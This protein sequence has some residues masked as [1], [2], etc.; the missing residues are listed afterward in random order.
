MINSSNKRYKVRYTLVL[1]GVLA[2]SGIGV[3]GKSIL[4]KEGHFT[5]PV[6]IGGNFGIE[7]SQ[8]NNV[9]K[10]PTQT[11][12][13]DIAD[14]LLQDKLTVYYELD[15]MEYSLDTLDWN[16]QYTVSPATF[17]L[18]LQCLNPIVYLT[19]AYEITENKQYLECAEEFL[20]KWNEYR[21]DEKLSGKNN[22]VWYDHGTALR[23][24]NIIYYTLVA[25]EAQCLTQETK[26]LIIE[27]LNLHAE[28]LAQEVNYTKNHN[29][30]IFQDRALI[31]IAYFLNNENKQMWLEIAQERL[32]GQIEHAFTE[33]M[34]HVENS[35]G[36]Q[37]GVIELFR[38]ISEFLN[39][40]EDNFGTQLYDS[41]KESM[42]FMTYITKP[43]GVVASIGDTNDIVGSTANSNSYAEFNNAEFTYASTCGEEGTQPEENSVFYPKSG[44]YI[45]HNDWDVENYKQSTWTMFKSGFK[46]KTHKHADDN[47]FML[48]SKGYDIFVDPGWYNYTYG[49]KY[50]D[51]FISSLAHNSVIVDGKSY[52]VTDENSYK[53]G[54]Y[55]YESNDNYD[56]I[57][58]YNDMYNDV[59]IDRHFYN[60][61]DAIILYDD[62][63]SD[64]EHTYSQLFHASEYMEV[65]SASNNEVLFS[66]ADTEY[67]VRIKQLLENTTV[68]VINGG[69]EDGLFGHISRTMNHIDTID[70]VKF[71]ITG[72]NVELVTLITIED[73]QGNIQDIDD[74]QFNSTDMI[75]SIK[76]NSDYTIKLKSRE[77]MSVEDI[78]IIQDENEFTFINNSL[79]EDF[80]Y[81]W[82]VIDK[83]NGK[84]IHKQ[85]Y[86]K[87]NHFAYAFNNPGEYLVR[88]Y[89]KNSKGQ[90]KKAIVGVISFNEESNSW[91]NNGNQYP[92]LNLKY[93]GHSYTQLDSDTYEFN[94][95]YNYSLNS[96]IKWYIYKNSVYYDV[97]STE[98]NGKL[99]YIFDEPGTYTIMYYL[100]TQEKDNEFYNFPMITIN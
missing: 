8:Y 2:I 10:F 13:I 74:I 1:I 90:M 68:N 55:D 53:T 40:F 30:G 86:S 26:G 17:Q 56:Y 57:V 52:S 41:I 47:S 69:S 11:E 16:V 88:G 15:S 19:R 28:F 80:Y 83:E 59:M 62:I 64:T 49:D 42:K 36:Y 70:T 58:G 75:F 4:S 39:Q 24:E 73:K 78:E 98:N 43:N 33:E 77:R 51:Y 82:Y 18:Y 95:N 22:M 65:I 34:V 9:Y 21:E 29:H 54:I 76:N 84:A 6:Y 7:K 85:E 97:C 38:V 35:P 25:E 27:L 60:L 72:N 71:D 31:Y 12:L 32:K 44:Y 89:I 14:G 87:E 3:V 100:T 23:A 92:Y 79:G 99:Q 5:Q 48:Y 45:S 91:K 93:N 37:M 63:I 94:V 50:R 61:G 20:I 66:L 81:A 46:S 67:N 96:K